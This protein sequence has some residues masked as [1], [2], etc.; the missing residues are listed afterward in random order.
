MADA[1]PVAG[2]SRIPP[3]LP[4]LP[5]VDEDDEDADR[6][7]YY[8]RRKEYLDLAQSVDD[9]DKLLADLASYLSTFQDNL[10]DVSG[11]VH[12]LQSRS[13]S[14]ERQLRGRRT[15]IPPLTALLEEII[16]P[17]A[18]V[19][20]LRDTTPSSAPDQWLAAVPAL[21]ARL[22][23]TK[24]RSRVRA[25]AELDAVLEPLAARVLS[26]LP[27]FLL[28]L[29][30]PLR[31]AS[32][33]LGTN[34]PVLQT[35]LLLKY[36]PFYAFL[37]RHAPRHAKQVERGYV[38]AARAYYETGF[39]RYARALA[40]IK[41]RNADRPELVG[42]VGA[43]ATQAVLNRAPPAVRQAYDRL[44]FATFEADTD[45]EGAGAGA[46]VTLAYEADDKDRRVPLEALF[47]SLALVLLDNASS[48]F[49]FIVRFF[50]R[51]T[52]EAGAPNGTA[53]HDARSRAGTPVD[54][55]A[56]GSD[57]LSEA[58]KSRASVPHS[59]R[60]RRGAA[61]DGDG[62]R[63]AERVWHEVFDPALESCTAFFAS[64]LVPTPGAITLLTLI[65]LN[66]A[67]LATADARGTTP[68]MPYLTGWKMALWPAYRKEM[69]RQVDSVKRLA[70]EA[71]G[72]G[73]A[74]VFGKGVKDGVVGQVAVRYAGL[75][76]CVVALADEAEEAMLFS[77]TSRLRAELHRLI[78][79]QAAKIKDA[80]Q[81]N[82]FLSATGESV[83]RELVA[84]PGAGKGM[85]TGVGGRMMEEV[86]WW[87]AREAEARRH[88]A[89]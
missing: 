49:T 37:A 27:A 13:D 19:L 81:R 69:D 71:E 55:P 1:E 72:K 9:S 50:A 6:E 85:G 56:L 35:S 28:T 54:S 88:T 77:S 30:K 53:T 40:Q 58:G 14:I 62:L 89:G 73:L 34:L 12:D 33:G 52:S 41:A 86:G 32:R 7:L 4:G 10:S 57:A 68:L 64:A 83:V 48:E 46:G 66:D 22:A 70:D 26:V 31:S 39:R 59:A 20:T 17:P 43:D 82:S 44:V 38:N 42:V 3:E 74:G 63:E 65:R 79:A 23:A 76:G 87:K 45:S 60:R 25:A 80:A 15:I 2:P 16:V 47:R 67:V 75:Y 78:T 61:G 18:L 51:A 84:G 29:I 5:L 8:R 21:E 24:S 11:Q 36:Q